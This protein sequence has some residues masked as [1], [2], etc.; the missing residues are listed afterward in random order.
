MSNDPVRTASSATMP[1]SEMTAVSVV[2][3]PTS[4]T[5]LPTGSSTGS[6]APMAAAIGCSMSCGSAAPGP[7][8]GLGDGPLLHLGD[9]RRHADQHAGPVEPGDPDPLQQQPDHAL[10][11]VEVGDGAAAQR[12]HGDDVAGRAADHLPGLVAG[13][14]HLAAL[15]VQGDDRRLVQH[16]AP[17]LGVH[18]GVGRAEVDGQVASQGLLLALRRPASRSP[19]PGRAGSWRPAA[20]DRARGAIGPRRPTATRRAP[21]PASPAGTT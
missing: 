4:M 18:Q 11:D 15:A 1:P 14:Q 17:A 19:R 21:A 12:A 16:D 9:G 10:G 5:R 3:P 13:R 7:P 2:P 6:P 8:G 20:A